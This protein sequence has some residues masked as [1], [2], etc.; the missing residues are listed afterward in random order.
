[1]Q[2]DKQHIDD[3]FRQ[4]EEAYTPGEQHATAHWQ[5]MQKQL[6]DPGPGASGNNKNG[7]NALRKIGKFLGAL[8][9]VAII[10]ILAIN[11]N[12]LNKKAITKTKKQQ[13]TVVAPQTKP[14]TTT[15]TLFNISKTTNQATVVTTPTT[16]VSK[17][18][19]PPVPAMTLFSPPITRAETI[20][21]TEENTFNKWDNNIKAVATKGPKPDAQTLLKLFYDQLKKKEESFYI[22]AGRDNTI[23]AKEGTIL[24][25]PANAFINKNGIAKGKVK[26][27]LREYYKYEDMVA[28]RLSTTSNGKQLVTGGMLHISAE[29]DGEAVK[30]APQKAIAV[31][32]PTDD[33][34]PNMHLFKGVE[35]PSEIDN[36][37][38][39]N[40]IRVGPLVQS[41]FPMN[42]HNRMVKVLNLQKVEPASVTYGKKTTAKFYVSPQIK[43][44]QTALIAA[45]KQRFGTYYDIIKL[46][47]LRKKRIHAPT[48]LED[49][50]SI[51]DSVR[52]DMDKALKWRLLPKNDSIYYAGLLKQDSIERAKRIK[53]QKHYQFSIDDLG[54]INCDF[55]RSFEYTKINLT[56]DVGKD[57]NI[58]NC[59]SQLVFTRF[60]SVL[61]LYSY[62]GNKIR[63]ENMPEKEPVVLIMVK[64]KDD[65][66]MTCFRPLN[67]SKAEVTDLVFE[68]TTPE[69]FKQKLQ[70]LFASPQQ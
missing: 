66:V 8:L 60:K 62:N 11:S 38:T 13:A 54:W 67:I 21:Q 47:K 53:S 58:S 42:M 10:A 65:T 46:K 55:F 15:D 39:L 14:V 51:I 25:I 24:A 26:I 28:A 3:F 41:D 29:Q 34:N 32:V 1:M 59:F 61:K 50:L 19:P 20:T 40:W 9:T 31:S 27:V 6:A 16:I 69:Q 18:A 2:S 4:K 35:Q 52:I 56:V 33:Y 36:S 48:M 5:Q 7:S 68:P 64:V 17:Q 12:R 44:S 22:E 57:Y 23:T 37:T 70:S 30:I 49:N 45:L 43:I 63:Y